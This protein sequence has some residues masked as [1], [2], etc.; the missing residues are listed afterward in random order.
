[1]TPFAGDK[2]FLFRERSIGKLQ[3]SV[4]H[5]YDTQ[6]QSMGYNIHD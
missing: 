4:N 1:M 5:G 6:N 3:L 2:N